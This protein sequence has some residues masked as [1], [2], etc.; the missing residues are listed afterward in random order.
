MANDSLDYFRAYRFVFD[1][2][3]WPQNLLWGALAQL[4]PIV[5]QI[6]FTG[7]LCEVL[8]ALHKGG[9]RGYPDFDTQRLVEYFKRGVWPFLAM[10]V[11]GCAVMPVAAL[12]FGLV[13]AVAVISNEVVA[14]A[15]LGASLSILVC[16]VISELVMTPVVLRTIFLR[17]L[18][19]AFSW[20][21]IRDFASRT[22]KEIILERLFIW[23]SSIGLMLVG[24]ALLVV[25][26]YPA[27][28]LIA[29]AQ[30]H[31][32]YQAY[33]IHLARGGMPITGPV[34]EAEVI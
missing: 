32:M 5:G 22:W 11:I 1:S 8:D 29:F 18:G 6:A 33:R 26:V 4:V 21:F 20:P 34:L 2:P 25:G 12:F 13:V 23:V 3:K 31:F 28:A 17:E 16:T 10:L 24:L 30:W 15:T 14:V 19:P 9:D 7:Y 27:A